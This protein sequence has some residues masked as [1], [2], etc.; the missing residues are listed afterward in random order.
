MPWEPQI[1]SENTDEDVDTDAPSYLDEHGDT[2]YPNIE[3]QLTGHDGNA[4]MIIGRVS[5]ALRR[6]GVEQGEIDDFFEQATSG[7]YNNVL[8]TCMRWVNVQ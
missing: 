6:A 4:V 3:V 1:T 2:R 7:D 8:V 5:R